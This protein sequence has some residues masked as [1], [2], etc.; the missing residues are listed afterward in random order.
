MKAVIALVVAF[1]LCVATR[2]SDRE[3][4]PELYRMSLNGDR[5]ERVLRFRSLSDRQHND[6][7]ATLAAVARYAHNREGLRRALGETARSLSEQ[8]CCWM[9]QDRPSLRKIERRP[10]WQKKTAIGP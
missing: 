10:T 4:H 6:G 7:T 2:C 5:P 9:T 1:C 3:S 8:S